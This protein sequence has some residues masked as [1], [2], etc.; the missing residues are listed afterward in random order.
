MRLD[1][2]VLKNW[3]N[4]KQVDIAVADRLFVYGPNASGKSNLLDAI[5]FLGDLT[6]P[7]GGL[8][9]S[10]A[11]RQGM[12]LVRSLASRNANKGL[13]TLGVFLSEGHTEW[14]YELSITAE[15]TGLKRPIVASE[16][17][18]RSGKVLLERPDE[19]DERDA[20]RATQT[21]LEQ[22]GGNKAFR[23]IARF[24]G[25]VRYLHLVPQVI[26]DP[27]R[28][29][30]RVDDPFGGDFLARVART[31][32]KERQRRLRVINEA[33][34]VAVPQLEGIEL[35]RDAD[36]RPH[37]GARYRH[38]RV[39]GARQDETAFSDGTLRLIGLLWSLQEDGRET[40][41]I[42]LEE[43]ELSL[44]EAVVSQ[45]PTIIYRASKRS[46]RQVIATTHAT[47]LL[48]D[49]GLGLDEVL[50]LAPSVE[51]TTAALAKD[52]PDVAELCRTGHTLKE[53]LAAHLLP[54][55]ISALASMS[56]G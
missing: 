19:D 6:L 17:V 24:L 3:R 54:T 47:D 50:V 48:N 40:G 7:G 34:K 49:E 12:K 32:E 8:Q 28:S 43:P 11:D 38:W 35:L 9:R 51:G 16:K 2:I 56:F 14:E 1:R 53:S 27:A 44:H 36:Q 52:L 20:E 5:R 4:F 21:A 33:L 42:L 23:E 30:D 37:L 22:V 10:V 45:L 39:N 41:P 46:G 13:V 25:S 15:K 31:P 55:E 29:G 18:V 26:R